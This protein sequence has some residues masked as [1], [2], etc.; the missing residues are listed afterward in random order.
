MMDRFWL[1]NSSS[2]TTA[3]DVTLNI[4]Y[5]AAEIGGTNTI[6]AANLQAIRYN[7]GGNSWEMPT[8]MYG[9]ANTVTNTLQNGVVSTT[10][11]HKVWTMVDTQFVVPVSATDIQT[12]CNTFTWID[13]TVYTT[14][15]NT[16]TFTV[17]GGAANGCDSIVTL[18]LTINNTA[19]GT[20]TQVA[21]N[22]FSW[23]DGNTYTTNNNS[24]TH[25]IVGGAANGCDSIVTLDL[26]IN[27]VDITTTTVEVTITANATPPA[28]YQWIDCKNGNAFI[29]GETNQTYTATANGDYA[30]IV[31]QNG[32]TDTSA[33][34]NVITVGIEETSNLEAQTIVVYP[35][36]TKNSITVNLSN[37]NN[38]DKIAL[39]NLQGKLIY[40]SENIAKNQLF[41][42]LSTR[43]KGV[44]TL[45]ILTKDKLKTM[46]IIKQ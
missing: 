24:A 43:S 38:V 23:I 4:G 17:V 25:T 5:D 10:D 1:L 15:T 46:K 35:N 40:F 42:D 18:D 34:V 21:C 20:D 19:T 13:N 2:Y 30:V 45:Q 36:P 14:T 7:L 11:F 31:T 26:T 6:T 12:A 41:I 39:Y 33:C 32:C 3:P 9:T 8:K 44:Y 27:T 22:T 16:P 37:S 28:T 29:A